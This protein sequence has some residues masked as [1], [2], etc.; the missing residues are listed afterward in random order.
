MGSCLKRWLAALLAW[1][2]TSPRWALCTTLNHHSTNSQE[3]NQSKPSVFFSIGIFS[4]TFLLGCGCLVVLLYTPALE[5]SLA[6]TGLHCTLCPTQPLRHQIRCNKLLSSR[7]ISRASDTPSNSLL[8]IWISCYF[9]VLFCT[10][11][12]P[13]IALTI[14]PAS[15]SR[16]R[17][18]DSTA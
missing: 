2:G 10:R 6:R 4:P 8:G 13:R 5:C 15:D 14:K 7:C 1:H 11:S 17:F 16:F 9:S 12:V 18:L 3:R